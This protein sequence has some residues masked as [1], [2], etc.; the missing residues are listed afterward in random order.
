MPN[1][2]NLCGPS[3]YGAGSV[4]IRLLTL[5]LVLL[6]VGLGGSAHATSYIKAP[7]LIPND[8]VRIRLVD[9]NRCLVMDTVPPYTVRWSSCSNSYSFHFLLE[10]QHPNNNTYNWHIKSVQTG[11]CVNTFD[12]AGPNANGGGCDWDL[13]GSPSKHA[14]DPEGNSQFDLLTDT[15]GWLCLQES[16]YV[17]GNPAIYDGCYNTQNHHRV[18][19]EHIDTVRLRHEITG[20]CPYGG[21]NGQAVST[22]ACWNDPSMAIR[23][24]PLGGNDYRIRMISTGQCLYGSPDSGGTVKSW[25]CWGDPG[26]VWTKQDLGNNRFH[27]QHKSTGQCMYTNPGN[28]LP[29]QNWPCW[30]DPAMVW[31]ADPF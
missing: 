12:Q 14:L 22:W 29:I 27:L 11:L 13:Y 3:K 23:M 5:T 15:F 24:E 2:L 26:M 21:A 7:P 19:I 30:M 4:L 8:L 6:M 28:G 25:G 9:A 17:E 18:Y 16:A 31:I 1:A 10:R 20:K